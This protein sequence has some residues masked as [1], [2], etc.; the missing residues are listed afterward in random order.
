M[1]LE[2]LPLFALSARSD[3]PSSDVAAER[4]EKSGRRKTQKARVLEALRKRPGCTSAELAY[5]SGLD[6]VMVARRLPDLAFD[7]KAIQGDE[8]LCT[9]TRQMCVSWTAV[10]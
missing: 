2:G 7:G 1:D 10:S 5:G 4:L 3:P 6:R 8:K 9:I